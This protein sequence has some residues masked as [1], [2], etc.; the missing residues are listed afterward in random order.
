MRRLKARIEFKSDK[1]GGIH[2]GIGKRS[3]SPQQLLVNANTALDAIGHAKP[4][5][6]KG[7]LIKTLAV[8]TSMGPGIKVNLS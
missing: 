4:A 1:Q 3:F 6:V 2:V 8:S 7:I 5:A